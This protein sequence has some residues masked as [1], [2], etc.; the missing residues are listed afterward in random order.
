MDPGEQSTGTRDENYSLIS[1]LYHTLQ[2]AEACEVYVMDAEATS[3]SALAAFL[4]EAQD[5]QAGLWPSGRM[6]CWAL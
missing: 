3:R 5:M 4:R 2:G 1:V 6:G